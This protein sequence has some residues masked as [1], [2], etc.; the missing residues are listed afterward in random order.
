V[1]SVSAPVEI[2]DYKSEDRDFVFSSW[3]R[4]YKHSSYFAKR[5]R[6]SVFFF[7]HQK[8][9]DAIVS[10]P[11]ARILVAC[12]PGESDVILGYLVMEERPTEQVIHY[13]FV[14]PEFRKMGIGRKLWLK[15]EVKPTGAYFTHWTFV[16]NDLR[17][18]M[19]ELTYDPYR[20]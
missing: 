5:I 2:R 13:V 17:E 4:N 6:N 14:K 20:L 3:L 12:A 16:V 1:Q 19:P 7:W 18:K 9:A 8:I 10:R 11:S 15:A